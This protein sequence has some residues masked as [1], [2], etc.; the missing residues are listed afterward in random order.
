[1]EFKR[2]NKDTVTCI[3]TEDD[4]DEQG[5]K[6]EDLFEKKKEAM[7][8]L[9]D[10]M[11]KAQEEVDYKPTGSFMPMQITVLP[12]HSISLTLSENAS[13]SFGEILK[14]LT[15]KAGITIP[16]NVLEDIGD[17]ENGDRINRLNEYLK[18][19]K[20]FTNSVKN[21]ME[22]SGLAE[23]HDKIPINQNT[24][25]ADNKEKADKITNSASKKNKDKERLKFHEYVFSFGNINTVIEFCKKAPSDLNISSSLYKNEKD[26][27]YYLDLK[28]LDEEPKVFASLFTMAYEFGHFQAS[29]QHVI[30]H[31][32]ESYDLII[33]D[34]AINSL[35]QV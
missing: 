25:A 1:M 32:R 8:F 6:L 33:K 27:K 16:K 35:A 22:E 20:Q 7:D 17:S 26:G 24:S 30:A 31:I 12:D 19:L 14:N 2:I 3:I 5:I 18:S 21:I 10:V 34:D 15:E 28:R 11:R 4:M 9:H 13:A 23:N 29:N